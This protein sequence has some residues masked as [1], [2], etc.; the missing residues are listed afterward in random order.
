MNIELKKLN[1]FASLIEVYFVQIVSESKSC[2]VHNWLYRNKNTYGRN[3]IL[4]FQALM[5]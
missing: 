2:H 4:H 5:L 3:K 1:K